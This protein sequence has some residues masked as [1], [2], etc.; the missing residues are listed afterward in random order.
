MESAAV[1]QWINQVI[2]PEQNE[3]HKNNG[4]T[5]ID[6]TYINET[7]MAKKQPKQQEIREIIA[8]SLDLQRL[9]PKETAALLNCTDA[10]LWEEI[11]A[12]GLKIKEKV[13]GRRIV[14]FAP[15]YISNYCVNNCVY[16]GYRKSNE[17][18]DRQQLNMDELREE[19]KAL[20]SKGHKRLI[21]VY[22]EHPRSDVDYIAETLKVA[23]STKVGNGEIRRANVNAAPQSIEDYRKLKEVGIGTFQVFQETYHPTTYQKLHPSGQL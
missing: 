15:L 7:L 19:I 20:V 16:C 21:M 13:Y 3:K 22:G 12:T 6:E 14:T 23:Y 10:D 5:F 18:I 9:D 2:K 8:K 1:Q 11:Y 17:H 4:K